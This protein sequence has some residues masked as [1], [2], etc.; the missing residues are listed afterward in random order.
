M[1]SSN[2]RN[3]PSF[4]AECAQFAASKND[5][6]VE[7]MVLADIT[8]GELKEYK[9]ILKNVEV[10]IHAVH[11][12]MG[13][14]AG[15][16]SLEKQNRLML[17]PAQKAADLLNAKSIVVHAGNGHGKEYL[18]ETVRQ[19]KLFND[20]RIVVENLPY[21]DDNGDDLSGYDASE[22]KYIMEESG[23]GFCFDFSHAACAAL[24]LG[25]DIDKQ[26]SDFFALKPTVYHLCD[27]DINV[28]EDKHFHYGEGN[29][30][31]PHF[32]NDF[33]ADDAYITMETG[34][35]IQQHNDLWIKDYEYLKSIQRIHR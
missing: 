28:A 29:Y 12:S 14:D 15:N 18:Q 22:I 11:S 6:F 34:S 31:L 35:G 16:R 30:P 24:T 23:C 4:V 7:L 26:M 13:F 19:F 17:E 21:F 8:D 27:G 25:I 5:M 33:T 20:K 32:L 10:R 9:E 2:L 3:A 1:F